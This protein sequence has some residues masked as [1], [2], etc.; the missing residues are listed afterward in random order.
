M[1]WRGAPYQNNGGSMKEENILSILGSILDIS[2]EMKAAA[3]RKTTIYLI[4]VASKKA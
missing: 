1:V 4:Y 3:W 2:N